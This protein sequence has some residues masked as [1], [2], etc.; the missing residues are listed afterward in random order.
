MASDPLT[1]LLAHRHAFLVD[2]DGVVYEGHR[3]IPGAKEFFAFLRAHRMPFHLITNN[4]TRTA[5][6]VAAHLQHLDMPVT[7]H[8]VLTSPEATAIHVEHICK[9]NACIY[10]IGE[11]G[12]VRTLIAH[13]FTLTTNPDRADAV[14]CGLDRRLTYDRLRRAC[15]A[16]R[17][18]VPLIAT[19]PDRALP[20]ETGFLP[21]NGATLAYLQVATGVTPVI[22]GKPSPTMLQIAMSRMGTSP[23]ETVMIGDG[24][25]TDILAGARASVGTILVLSGVAQAN[26]VARATAAPDAVVESIATVWQRLATRV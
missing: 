12:L 25:E 6:D 19:N 24:L 9:K 15:A 8:D 18:G 23:A 13:G 10:A 21:G 7:E 1:E 26:D 4:S 14:V 3:A 11:D 17:R 20:T 2:L 22:I 16:L 5:S